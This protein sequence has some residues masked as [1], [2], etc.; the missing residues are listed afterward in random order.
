[1]IQVGVYFWSAIRRVGISPF[2]LRPGRSFCNYPAAR[3]ADEKLRQW[4]VKRSTTRIKLGKW[5]DIIYLTMSLR[6]YREI[7]SRPTVYS[8]RFGNCK[9]SL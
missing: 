2:Y 5:N 1:M 9:L 4:E 6:Q 3:T 8:S 7:Q